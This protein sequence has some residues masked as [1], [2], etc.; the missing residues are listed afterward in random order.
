MALGFAS[1]ATEASD[2]PDYSSD[3]KAHDSKDLDLEDQIGASVSRKRHGGRIGPPLYGTPGIDSDTDSSV[4]VTK[5]MEMES[6]NAIKYRTCSWQKVRTLAQIPKMLPYLSMLQSYFELMHKL[7]Y[8]GFHLLD[9]P[10]EAFRQQ[11]KLAAAFHIVQLLFAAF[12]AWVHA[13]LQHKSR[14]A[15]ARYHNKAL[16]MPAE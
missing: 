2:T 1:K 9:D 10:S 3:V 8:C 13:L 15:E 4:D 16:N 11:L 14:G 5:Q 6:E 12:F 7:C